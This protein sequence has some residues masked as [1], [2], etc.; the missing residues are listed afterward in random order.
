MH[1]ERR[2]VLDRFPGRL[3]K[4]DMRSFLAW[5]STEGAS[6]AT[7]GRKLACLRSF[8]RYLGRAGRCTSNPVAG[9]RTPRPDRS[10]PT[11]LS[12]PQVEQV[13]DA[14]GADHA[15]GSARAARDAALIETL[16]GGGL[17]VGELVAIDD[18]DLD[19]ASGVVRVRGKGKKERIAPLGGAAIAAIGEYMAVRT[20]REGQRALFVN[21]L[22]RRL[23][24]RSVARLVLALRR[25]LGLP[26]RTTPHSFRHSFATHLLDRG[27]DLRSV[28][29]LLGH[30]SLATTQVYTH[31]TAER[32]Q[33]AYRSAHP[34]S[35]GKLV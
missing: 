7:Q 22:G 30:A 17:R 21:R 23:S 9:I 10:L 33:R 19:L 1:L 16:Y 26:E 2:G 5:L 14:A 34:R 15:P 31:V 12:V 11:F 29:E 20:R 8:Y 6:R 13:I 25:R 35:R 24:A 3:T 27:A 32:M 18:D 4:A 28:Q